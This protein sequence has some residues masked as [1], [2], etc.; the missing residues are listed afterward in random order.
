MSIPNRDHMRVLAPTLALALLLVASASLAAD[1]KFAKSA[2]AD[3]NGDG[4]SERVYLTIS[5]DIST[6]ST[7]HMGT[8]STAVRAE[9]P[10]GLAVVDIDNRDRLKEIVVRCSNAGDGWYHLV[11]SYDGKSIALVGEIG[12]APEF[13]G[14]G[15]VYAKS[16][17]GSFAIKQKFVLD[18]KKRKLEEL[19]QPM[20]Y[21]GRTFRT[22]ESFA[23]HASTQDA[24]VVANI[25]PKSQI[26]IVALAF[27]PVKKK[28]WKSDKYET[29][30]HE[31]YLIKSQSGLMGW[32]SAEDVQQHVPV[33]VAG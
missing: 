2:T 27:Q 26:L 31:W 33:S 8:T 25:E 3:L 24:S 23:I 21:I 30:Q 29:I 32:A 22:E 20:Y 11:Y 13:T 10:E 17:M 4:R 7:L 1:L 9:L 15:I 5:K 6:R 19:R 18:S 12:T 28:M 14:R 16:W